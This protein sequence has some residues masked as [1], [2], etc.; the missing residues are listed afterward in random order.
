MKFE[1][2]EFFLMVLVFVL[3]FFYLFHLWV[4]GAIQDTFYSFSALWVDYYTSSLFF[5]SIFQ[6]PGG[7]SI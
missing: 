6:Y 7:E 3:A 5:A 4:P 1:D 2:E